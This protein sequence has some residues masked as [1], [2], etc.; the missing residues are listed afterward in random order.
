MHLFR[1]YHL[2][3]TLMICRRIKRQQGKN[4]VTKRETVDLIRQDLTL[5]TRGS[6]YPP[7]GTDILRL[8]FRFVLNPSQPLPSACF[9][10]YRLNADVVYCIET[11]GVRTGLRF[12]KR[13]SLPLSVLPPDT[14]GAALSQELRS[15][16][17]PSWRNFEF[18]KDV[19]RGIWGAHSKVHVIVGYTSLRYLLFV[20]K[21]HRYS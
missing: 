2:I 13:L 6:A 11:V 16:A 21:C 12:N 17:V 18:K 7:A 3:H 9:D 5:W 1:G 19:R 8:P 20:S 10:A 4:A 15:G 14:N